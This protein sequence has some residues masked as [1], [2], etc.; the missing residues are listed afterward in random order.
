MRKF[1]GN[2][3]GDLNMIMT[4]IILAITLAIS[5]LIVWNIVGAIEPTTMDTALRTSLGDPWWN[6]TVNSTNDL[7]T[8]IETFYTVAPI[9]LI[10][11]AAV[12]I[13]SYVM[14]LR[15]T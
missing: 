10:V 2:R 12:G 3:H 15:R 13:L 1:L 4:A 7:N 5:I 9:V 11:V 8:N 14:L 6:G